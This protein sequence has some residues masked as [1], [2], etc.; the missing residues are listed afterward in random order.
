M[1]LTASA[2]TANVAASTTRASPTPNTANQQP[3]QCR[4]REAQP[5]RLH[6]LAHRVGLQQ[7]VARHDVRHD[8]RER[9]LE[10]RLADPVDHDQCDHMPELGGL[11]ERQRGDGADR[12]EPQQVGDDQQPAAL[13]AVAEH[14]GDQQRRDHRQRPRESDES[15]CGRL[16]CNVEHEPCDRNQVDAVADE[17]DRL[18]EPEQP[19]VAVAQ[20]PQHEPG[21]LSR[22]GCGPGRRRQRTVVVNLTTDLLRKSS[23]K[24]AVPLY[25]P[26]LMFLNRIECLPGSSRF[27]DAERLAS[28]DSLIETLAASTSVNL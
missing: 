11:R 7:L 21:R 9:R 16:V 6:Q 5:E 14:A 1:R 3:A 26:D 28:P 12:Y 2:E 25:R 19:E 23:V 13:E 15:E 24:A 17:R 8:R 10:E 4:P 18:A 27:R 20:N 22:P